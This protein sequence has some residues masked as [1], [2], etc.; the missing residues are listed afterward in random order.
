[1]ESNESYGNVGT[2]R[3]TPTITQVIE[4]AKKNGAITWYDKT[5]DNGGLWITNKS[6]MALVRKLLK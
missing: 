2:K 5:T 4:M 6:L 3:N 1:M